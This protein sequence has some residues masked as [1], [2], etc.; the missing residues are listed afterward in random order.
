M[1]LSS[2]TD[3]CFDCRHMVESNAGHG[4]HVCHPGLFFLSVLLCTSRNMLRN[5]R[6]EDGDSSASPTMPVAF[7]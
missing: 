5:V 6:L 3:M 4:I 7:W 2:Y 1:L